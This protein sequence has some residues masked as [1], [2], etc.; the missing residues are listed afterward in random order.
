MPE[1]PEVETTLRG[2]KPHLVGQKVINVTVRHPRLRWPIPSDIK[3]HLEGQTIR[4][5]YRRGKYLLFEFKHGTMILHLGMSGRLCV[6]SKPTPAQKH[7]HVDIHF[8][9]HRYL[10]FTD[11]R[12]FGALLWTSEDPMTHPL[13]AIIGPEPLSK[14]FDGDYLYHQ[15]RNRK[16]SVKS[17]VMNSAIVAGVGNIYATEALFQAG[18]HPHL[19]AGK[20]SREKYQT[21][22]T[23]IKQI[24]KKAIEKGGTTLKDF[25]KSDGTPGYFRIELKVYGHGGEPCPHC[26][27]KLASTRLGQRSTV[28]CRKCQRK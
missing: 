12:R 5:L 13:L 15:S 26:H 11:P 3:N 19:S 1:L 6:L 10:R 22:A 24:L 17:F 25:M 27:T 9:N 8:A 7:D 4:R 20:I 14:D 2:I 28:Y 23:A 21:L 18:I 16:V